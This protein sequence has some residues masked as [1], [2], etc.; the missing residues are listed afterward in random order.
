MITWQNKYHTS[1]S[2]SILCRYL[3]WSVW[4]PLRSCYRWC[5]GKLDRF[6][7]H[8]CLIDCLIQGDICPIWQWKDSNGSI[9]HGKSYLGSVAVVV[10]TENQSCGL[11]YKL[12]MSC[13][14]HT[15]KYIL[16]ILLSWKKLHVPLAIDHIFSPPGR[17][18]QPVLSNLFQFI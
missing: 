6:V 11:E 12:S 2:L 10:K 8:N 5:I 14:C 9:G 17:K 13:G 4:A 7:L 1:Q 16:Q 15:V 18:K 3:V